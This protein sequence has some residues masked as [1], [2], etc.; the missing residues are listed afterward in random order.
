MNQ[1]LVVC[2]DGATFDLLEPWI[3]AGCL[4]QLK[5][6]IEGGVRGNLESTCPP[7]TTPAWASF[8]TGKSP[9]GHGVYDF[10]RPDPRQESFVNSSDIKSRLFW[11]YLSDR[12]ITA[13]ILNLPLTYPIRPMN[14]YLVSG[15]LSPGT[16][17]SVY[18][19]GL[20][21]LFTPQLGP[22]RLT[23]ELLYRPGDETGFAA[24][25]M[26]ITEAQIRYALRMTR[27]IP[28]DLTIVHFL[29]PDILQHKLWRF[30]DPKHPWFKPEENP[31][32]QAT[33]RSLFERIDAGISEL[34]AVT[35][36][37]TN[38]LVISDHGFGP[39]DRLVNL[40]NH[41]INT[42]HLV[43]KKGLS[44][45][46]RF[47][48]ARIP[49]GSRVAW[50]LFRLLGRRYL[51]DFHDVDWAR[52]KAYSRGHIGQIHLTIQGQPARDRLTD[53]DYRLLQA[54]VTKVLSDITD[55]RT[56]S[57]LTMRIIPNEIANPGPFCRDGPDLIV[58][59]DDFNAIA[60]PGFIADGKVIT[61]QRHGDSGNHRPEGI[62]IANGPAFKRGACLK[63]AR[64][65][66]LAPTLLHLAGVSVP[67]DMEG[68][69]LADAY[70][71]SFL[72]SHPV[73]FQAAGSLEAEDFDYPL[74]AHTAL[75]DRLRSLG[76]LG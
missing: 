20:L 71:P 64:M 48:A 18:P 69:V 55:P 11:E 51:V 67:D 19:R 13:G 37:D 10:Y 62:L 9:G 14:G 75:G 5:G 44:T 58:L 15:L 4:P 42:G 54:E 24:E 3:Q 73:E 31:Q 34:R 38:C 7:L 8:M 72:D 21:D 28:T 50:R 17:D 63:G 32:I 74:V 65:I 26:E 27:D 39:I 33:V 2:L 66:D 43:L 30:L 57:S 53:R 76:Y 36:R 46:I 60:Y 1:T 41:L 59:L 23:S 49:A 45:K 22:Y 16:E 29:G 56:G 47:T 70:E 40:N 12:G 6:L 61:E 25:V 52:S 35:P 68:L